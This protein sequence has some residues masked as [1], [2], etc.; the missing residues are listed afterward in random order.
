ML[1]SLSLAIATLAISSAAMAADL[2][3]P[4]GSV[5]TCA[6]ASAPGRSTACDTAAT[7][8]PVGWTRKTPALVNLDVNGNGNVVFTD[9]TS[10]APWVSV[11]TNPGG[12]YNILTVFS[13]TVA[14]NQTFIIH[15]SDGL[16]VDGLAFAS[17]GY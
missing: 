4:N 1:K 12:Y 13:I 2:P 17:R 8:T 5:L 9:G 3:S 15:S 10:L 7:L 16:T 11:A 6:Q 14:N